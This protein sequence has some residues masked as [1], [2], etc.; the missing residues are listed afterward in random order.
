MDIK[1]KL[2]GVID[3]LYVDG[4]YVGN[5]SRTVTIYGE[6]HKLDAIAKEVGIELPKV[7]K[8]VKQ[9]NTK[10]EQHA[11]MDKALDEGNTE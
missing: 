2:Q 7:Q 3:T 8:P 9:V 5:S 10:E 4:V 11:D 1:T 6:T